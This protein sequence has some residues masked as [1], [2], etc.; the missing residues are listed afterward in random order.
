MPVLIEHIKNFIQHIDSVNGA[1]EHTLKAYRIDLDGFI[2]FLKDGDEEA[3]PKLIDV[4]NL[5]IRKYAQ[6]LKKAKTNG[7]ATY[8]NTTVSRKLAALRSFL[9]YMVRMGKIENNPGKSVSG[10]KKEKNL[11]TVLSTDEVFHFLDA[12]T[13]LTDLD[14]RDLA[15]FELAYSSGL[16]ISELSGLDLDSVDY[17]HRQVKVF[18]KG[19]KERIVPVGKK[20]IERIREWLKVREAIPGENALFV[21]YRGERLTPRGIDKKLRQRTLKTAMLKEITPHTLRHTF[22]THLLDSGA[23]LRAIQE[24]LGHE[25]LSTTQKYTHV[26]MAKLSEVYDGAHPRSRRK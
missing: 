21:N 13:E 17:S 4:T 1:S 16:R 7:K 12:E 23:D 22:A 18:G 26:S 6:A 24:M 10:P 8:K 20:A 9:N 14:I 3:Q 19:S 11:P 15:I 5:V 25:S 2:S